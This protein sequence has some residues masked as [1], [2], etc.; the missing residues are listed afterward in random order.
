VPR[1]E[2]APSPLS[3][4]AWRLRLLDLSDREASFERR[5]FRAAAS[6]ARARLEGIGRTFLAGYRSALRDP[7]PAPLARSLEGIEPEDR[8]FAYEGAAMALGLLD[9][10]VPWGFGRFQRFLQG[11]GRTHVHLVHVGAGWALA[12]VPLRRGALLRGLDPLL[13]W[14][15]FDGVGFHQGYF[16][17]R[18]AIGRRTRPGWLSGYALRAFDQGLGRSL[19]F[20]EGAHVPA[21]AAAIARFEPARRAD[22]WS[23]VGLA[24]AYAGGAEECGLAPLRD[25]AGEHLAAAAQGAAFAAAARRRA[26][27]PAAGHTDRVCRL[28]CGRSAAEAAAV[29][30]EALAGLTAAGDATPP[31]EE[32]RQRIQARFAGA[33]S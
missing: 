8:G 14:L 12:R 23:G 27:L 24:S 9:L 22:L 19:W 17:H 1:P 5:R 11:P 28:L 16:H 31:Y 13:R 10:L 33:R 25:A 32:W 7:D 26:G 6:S 30:E 21:I 29:T 20:V 15:A 4:A 3:A 2:S 18:R